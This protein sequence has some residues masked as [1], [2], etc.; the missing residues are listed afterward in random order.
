MLLKVVIIIIKIFERKYIIKVL[1][2]GR[3]K[4]L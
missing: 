4:E 3:K 2:D 1:N